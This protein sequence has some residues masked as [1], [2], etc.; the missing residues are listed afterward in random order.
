MNMECD[1]LNIT[2]CK[3]YVCYLQFHY[4]PKAPMNL[5]STRTSFFDSSN[6]NG[7]RNSSNNISNNS[8]SNT[9]IIDVEVAIAIATGVTIENSNNNTKVVYDTA[10]AKTTATAIQK[11]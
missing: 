10:I 6:S 4:F 11:L 8:N 2:H 3:N 5:I 9:I 7:N 1:T